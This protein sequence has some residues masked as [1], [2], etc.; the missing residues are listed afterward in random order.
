MAKIRFFRVLTDFFDLTKVFN[1]KKVTE[2]LFESKIFCIF[3]PFFMFLG[4]CRRVAIVHFGNDRSIG[5]PIVA[6][7]QKRQFKCE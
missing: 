3:W 2:N 1:I 4:I 7:V 6:A 5:T